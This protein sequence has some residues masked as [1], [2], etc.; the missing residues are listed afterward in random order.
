MSKSLT[1]GL[2]AVAALAWVVPANAAPITY[3]GLRTVGA[4]S[5]TLLI[6]TD[7][8]LGQLGASNITD[9][10]LLLTDPTP[11]RSFNN[12]SLTPGTSRLR[13]IG[14]ALT[15]TSTS[16]LFDFESAGADNFQF[17]EFPIVEG[18]THQFCVDTGGIC[19]G[20]DG[21]S[22]AVSDFSTNQN[23]L[24]VSR[25]GL[26][27]LATAPPIVGG[28]PEPAS[29]AMMLAGFG[30]VGSGFRARRRRRALA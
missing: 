1:R 28:V 26:A 16:L 3:T 2:M 29:W 20:L 19:T 14:D 24:A 22:E 30:I 9:W 6:T 23:F 8:T 27:V 7:G 18:A 17:F 15:A 10:T 5:V 4:Q 11:G 13:V 21:G 25:S 12:F